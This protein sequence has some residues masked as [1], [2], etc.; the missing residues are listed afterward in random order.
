MRLGQAGSGGGRGAEV[1]A[2]EVRA[3]VVFVP[4]H[5]DRKVAASYLYIVSSKHH[6]H[7][8]RRIEPTA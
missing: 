6:K 7:K 4:D 3:G 8:M 5:A 1:G 2:A